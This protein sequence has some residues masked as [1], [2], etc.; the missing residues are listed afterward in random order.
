MCEIQKIGF[1]KILRDNDEIFLSHLIGIIESVDELSSITILQKKEG[2]SFRIAPSVPRYTNHI[3]KE[4]INFN[5]L[6][7]IFMDMGKS[8][9]TSSTITFDIKTSE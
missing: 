8:I 7:G 9:K 2:F 3:L 1:N 4:I 5:N 6:Y